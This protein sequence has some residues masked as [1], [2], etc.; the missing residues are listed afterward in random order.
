MK[1]EL[2]LMEIQA[3]QSAIDSQ[4]FTPSRF[5]SK[6]ILDQ[7]EKVQNKLNKYMQEIKRPSVGRGGFKK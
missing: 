6:R 5:S 4:L 1:I 2:D 3:I 7:L